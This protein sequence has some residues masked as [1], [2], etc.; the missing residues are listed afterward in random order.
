M[1]WTLTVTSKDFVNTLDDLHRLRLCL[2]SIAVQRS[3]DRA[4]FQM[5]IVASAWTGVLQG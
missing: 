2:V 5:P 3:V 4:R 1:S